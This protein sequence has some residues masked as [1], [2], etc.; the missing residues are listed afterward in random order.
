M[1]HWLTFCWVF[2]PLQWWRMEF[3]PS[4]DLWSELSCQL[5]SILCQV[6]G[7][8]TPFY[9]LHSNNHSGV[10]KTE[11]WITV[12]IGSLVTV[13][14]SSALYNSLGKLRVPF[15]TLSF[16]FVAIISFMNWQSDSSGVTDINDDYGHNSTRAINFIKVLEGSVLR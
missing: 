1:L 8:S 11:L 6:S 3:H 7:P 12:C 16:N 2:I 10:S 14:L 15:M 5:C 9:P 4:M 13:F